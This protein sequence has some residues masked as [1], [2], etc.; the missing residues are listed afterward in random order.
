MLEVPLIHSEGVIDIATVTKNGN[1]YSITAS[2]TETVRL[3]RPLKKAHI[4][5]IG[6]VQ[7]P[8]I[9]GYP[10]TLPPDLVQPLVFVDEYGEVANEHYWDEQT[11]SQEV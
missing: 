2:N 3:D 9:Y 4:G 6:L 5:D 7:F 1:M 10:I 11:I 8:S